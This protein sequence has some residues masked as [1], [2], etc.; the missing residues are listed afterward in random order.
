MEQMSNW[1]CGSTFCLEKVIFEDFEFGG[2]DWWFHLCECEGFDLELRFELMIH[3]Y[4]QM[5]MYKYFIRIFGS[6]FELRIENWIEIF[7]QIRTDFSVFP[8]KNTEPELK[9]P[10][11]IGDFFFSIPMGAIYPLEFGY[12]DYSNENQL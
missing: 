1:A 4:K 3:T 8:E 5:Y 6:V 7:V 2:Y 9:R 11:W 10:N 12:S